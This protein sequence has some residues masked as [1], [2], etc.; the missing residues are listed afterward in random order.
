MTMQTDRSLLTRRD[1]VGYGS[2]PPDP[3]WPGQARLALNIVVNYEEGS[4]A[5]FED[6]D[7]RSELGLTEVTGGSFQG[8]DLAAE[9]M[10]EY[11]S[12]VG[13]WRVLRL[14]RERGMTATFFACAQALERN[15]AVA[16]AIREG[17][18][19]VCCHGWRW[20]PLQALS[21]AQEREEMQRAIASIERTT[22]Q[23]P[24][25]WY[26][27]YAPTVNTRKLV[28]EQGSFL[29]DSD[30]Y[31]D[32]LPYWVDAGDR[33]HLVIPYTQAHNDAKFV[34]SGIATA[35]DF[36]AFLRDSFDMLYAEGATQPKMMSVGLHM[37]LVGHPG[38]AAGLARFLDHVAAHERVWVCRRL[39]IARHWHASHPPAAR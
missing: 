26:C 11:G 21:E 39:D 19:D 30:S 4:E 28:L 25:G 2:T 8:R 37:R 17:G 16:Q 29:Y 33:H 7:G 9:S 14:L 24:A 27:R 5:S 36:Y 23:A 15:P 32:E 31:N 6:G 12:R 18:Y 35:D 10:F 1:F 3:Q 38:R 34:R 13:I 20:T 22:G